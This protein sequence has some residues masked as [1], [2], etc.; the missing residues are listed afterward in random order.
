MIVLWFLLFLLTVPLLILFCFWRRLETGGKPCNKLDDIFNCWLTFVNNHGVLQVM[1][2]LFMERGLVL[3]L[4][5]K[6]Q[7]G[8]NK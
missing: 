6:I 5:R 1:D 8:C 4:K 7:K 2:K 3:E